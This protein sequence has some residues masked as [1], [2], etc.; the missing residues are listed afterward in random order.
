MWYEGDITGIRYSLG[1]KNR[2]FSGRMNLEI[3][4]RPRK[5]SL[6][7]VGLVS[8]L[9][10]KVETY[11]GYHDPWDLMLAPQHEKSVNS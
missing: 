8:P 11:V 4:L 7:F 3:T 1:V 5:T 6:V 10:G 9:N 2:D